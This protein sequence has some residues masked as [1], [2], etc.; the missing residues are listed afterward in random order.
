MNSSPWASIP[1]RALPPPHPLLPLSVHV[2]RF[3]EVRL[4]ILLKKK[5]VNIEN[6]GT[7]LPFDANIYTLSQLLRIF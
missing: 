5:H 6:I 2:N 4:Y 7:N 3:F 1:S